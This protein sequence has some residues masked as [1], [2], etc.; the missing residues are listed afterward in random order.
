[1]SE[2]PIEGPEIPVTLP[3]ERGISPIAGRLA[4]GRR[5]KALGVT[6]LA[7]ASGLGLLATARHPQ[8]HAAAPEAPARQVVPYEPAAPTLAQPGLGPPT[9]T[10]DGPAPPAGGVVVPAVAPDGGSP[11]T[12]AG[13][14]GA[15]G[16]LLAFSRGSPP[17]PAQTAPDLAPAPPAHASGVTLARATRLPDRR[18][19]ILA[20]TAIPCILQTAMDSTT[21]GLVTCQIPTDVYS[22]DG[23]VVL[24]ERGSRVLGDYRGGLRQG[25]RRLYVAWTRAV[26]PRGVAIPLASP[27]TDALGRAGFDGEVD[28]HFWSRFGGALLLS[29][30]DAARGALGPAAH[31]VSLQAPSTAADTALRQSAEIAPTLRKAP[32]A[33]VSILV[34]QDLDFSGVY[35]VRRLR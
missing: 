32:G 25:Q 21:P 4:L 5:G 20:G 17:A 16:P 18:F 30:V 10:R 12:G 26:T 28:S 6:A 22:D 1:M 2:T 14:T 19:L 8:A 35:G 33:E 29:T 24:L 9:L 23:A 11:A 3:G 31:G 13:P 27:A 34:A 15:E 7:A